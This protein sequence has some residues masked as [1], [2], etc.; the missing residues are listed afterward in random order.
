[1]ETVGHLEQEV[2]ILDADRLL[3]KAPQVPARCAEGTEEREQPEGA[4]ELLSQL[5]F[6]DIKREPE[7]ATSKQ[8]VSADRVVSVHDPEMRLGW[9]CQ[10][11][12]TT[13]IRHW[14]W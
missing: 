13:A 4:A 14:S 7:G 9:C 5:L 8:R 12:R 11:T 1:M 10:G 6:Q 2:C 3:D